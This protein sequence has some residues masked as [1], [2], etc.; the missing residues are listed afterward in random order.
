MI[1]F[2][3]YEDKK[4]VAQEIIEYTKFPDGEVNVSVPK[5]L[6]FLNP[7]HIHLETNILSSDDLIALILLT[8]AIRRTYGDV[9][10]SVT[11]PYFPYARQDRVCNLGESLS[12]KVI[13]DLINSQNYSAVTTWDNHSDVATALLNNCRNITQKELFYKYIS[14][15]YLGPNTILVSPDAGSN[16][17]IFS[18]VMDKFPYEIIRADKVR[19]V[20]NGN[21]TDT[22]VYSDSVGDK[23][24]L[25]VDD[26]CTGGR[27]FIELAKKLK[28]ITVGKIILYVT[29]GSFTNGLDVFDQYIDEIYCANLITNKLTKNDLVMYNTRK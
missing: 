7:T 25:M 6:I 19:D 10:I 23:T 20:T 27:T 24:L 21:I 12:V 1:R 14:P 22:I 26:I 15:Q 17:K 28:E 3:L 2:D 13:A 16:K 9:D 18:I 8:D 11:I 5:S 4:Y 29:H